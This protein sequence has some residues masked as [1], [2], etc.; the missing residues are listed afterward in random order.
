MISVDKAL[1]ILNN[2]ISPLKKIEK[3]TLTHS[4]G[5]VLSENIISPINMPPFAQSAMDGYAVN[6][7]EKLLYTIIDEIK[8]GDH[9]QPKLKKGEAVRIF[10][11]SPVPETVNAIVI[12]EK[13]VVNNKT[14]KIDEAINPGANIRNFGEQVKKGNIALKKGVKLTPASIGFLTSLG[15]TEV[16]VFC[17]PTVAIVITGNEL[18]EAGQQLSYGKIYES[19]SAMLKAVLERFGYNKVSIH[20]VDDN[21]ENTFNKLNEVINNYDLVLVSGGISVGDYDFVGSALQKLNVETLFYKV[22]QKPGKPLFFGKKENTYVFAL[23]GNPAASLTCFY[24][25]V[26]TALQIMS[27]HLEFSLNKVIASSGSN[28]KKSGHR[29]QFL[30]AIYKNGTVKILEGQ[31]SSMLHTFAIS[32]A[33]VYLPEDQNEIKVKDKVE[34]ILLPLN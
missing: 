19:N 13:V 11:G 27:G 18:I 17:K 22:N 3:K 1:N 26:L 2:N 25:Y 34:T 15:I 21:F 7:H 32:N 4:C 29:S 31:N 5:Y 9:H 10:T 8:A 23:P 30:K 24:I 6:L 28:F 33:L 16:N 12:Q 14:I 20:K